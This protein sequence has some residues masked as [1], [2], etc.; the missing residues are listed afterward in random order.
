MKAAVYYEN[1]GPEVLKYEDFPDPDLHPRGVIIKVEAIAIEGGDTLNRWRGPLMTN[2]HVVGYQAAGEIV[3]VG[4]EVTHLKLG[5]KVATVNN[6]GSHAELRSVPA[7]NCWVIPDGFD[8]KKAAAIPVTFGTADDCLFEAGRLKAGETV[9]VQAGA[10]GVGV[11]AIQLAKRAGA[12]VLATASSDERLERL[13]PLGLDHGINYAREDVVKEVMRLTD[14]KGVDVVVDSVGGPTL[15]GSINALAYRGRVSMVGAAGREPM[16]VDV[17]A[18]MGGNRQLRGVFL[19]AEIMTDRVH[20]NIQRL[21]DEA[22]RG[23]LEVLIDK[24]FPLSDAA[25]A[26][27][28]IESRAAVGRVVLVP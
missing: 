9:L 2:P 26:H 5:Q 21:I 7:R 25:G 3:A 6:W 14:K 16:V 24:V 28:Y 1:G 17:G 23:E 10:S 4:A 19:G 8:V 27:A 12:T 20:D 11:A 22:A 15:Q 13:K 18:M